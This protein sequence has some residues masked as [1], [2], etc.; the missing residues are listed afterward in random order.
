VDLEIVVR[1]V[2][3]V[4]LEE[5]RRSAGPEYIWAIDRIGPHILESFC[6]DGCEP[7]L[8]GVI[9]HC[10][11]DS[12][13][14]RAPA[15]EGAAEESAADEKQVEPGARSPRLVGSTV[16]GLSCSASC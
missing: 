14:E 4:W 2:F 11:Y 8:E 15:G 10:E 3:D 5:L 16:V 12:L 9:R 7:S 1:S 13:R 6:K